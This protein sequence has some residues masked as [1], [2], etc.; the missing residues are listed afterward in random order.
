MIKRRQL[1]AHLAATPLMAGIPAMAQTY[2]DKAFE[3]YRAATPRQ[4]P[5]CIGQAGSRWPESQ[6]EAARSGRKPPWLQLA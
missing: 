2:P 1:L 5:R 6:L 3:N 4:P